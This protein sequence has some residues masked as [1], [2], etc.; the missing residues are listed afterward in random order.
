MKTALVC[1]AKNEN[2]YLREFIK[3][4]LNLGFDNIYIGDNNDP[5]GEWISPIIDDYID[6]KKVIV[7]NLRG[8]RSDKEKNFNT[9]LHYYNN[10]YIN[11]RNDYDWIAFIDCDEFITLNGF[12]NIKDYLSQEH[13]NSYD[14]IYLNWRCFMDSNYIKD[15]G[16]PVLERFHNYANFRGLSNDLTKFHI[17]P[18]IK[19]NLDI[20]RMFTTNPHI[21]L[22]NSVVACNSNG[23]NIINEE[24]HNI[25]ITPEYKHA[26]IRHY[27]TKTIEEFINYKYNRGAVDIFG[28]EHGN[29]H[30]FDYFFGL[31]NTTPEKIE[32]I[33][34]R[35]I[36]Y[37]PIYYKQLKT[38]VVCI[39]KNEGQYLREFVEYYK[40]LGFTRIIMYD[41]NDIDGETVYPVINDYIASGYVILYNVRGLRAIQMAAYYEAYNKYYKEYD[42]FAFIDCDERIVLNRHKN[43]SEY[44]SQERFNDAEGIT[45]FWKCYTDGN[46]IYNDG[47]PLMHRF[48]EESKT[49]RVLNVINKFSKYI[50]R[51][52]IDKVANNSNYFFDP[53][54]MP[55][56][57]MYDCN[58]NKYTVFYCPKNDPVYGDAYVNHYM[59]KTISEFIKQKYLNTAG[60]S[61]KI[62]DDFSYFFSVNE[63][64]QEKLD[65]IKSKGIEINIDE[66]KEKIKSNTL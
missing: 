57:K 34:S 52:N 5:E 51:G 42:W 41:N 32:Y 3:Y 14:I 18:I 39:V 23:Q 30:D 29:Y 36:N 11:I 59:T 4:H 46:M 63:I 1:I 31:N 19:G 9:N 13:F 40:N 28:I 17:K 56:D 12:D 25:A 35:G 21:I 64:T 60:T 54:A 2:R 15:D 45:L 26:Y 22:N 48:T 8:I 43:I 6:N 44:L 37:E 33:K 53:H 55:L 66:I 27:P 62:R 20:D 38:A 7:I 65:Y 61:G 49:N 24:T 47:R 10:I 50:I 16:R 58:G